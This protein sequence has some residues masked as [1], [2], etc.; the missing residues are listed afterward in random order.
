MDIKLAKTNIKKQNGGSLLTSILS[1]GRAVAPI[2]GK[3][4]DVLAQP[5][6]ASEGASQVV[7]K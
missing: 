7:K 5:G 6:L 3:T 1:L 2:L 4:L